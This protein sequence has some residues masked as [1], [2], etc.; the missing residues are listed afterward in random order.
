MKKNSYV[1]V[2]VDE[3]S[4]EDVEKILAN[5]GMNTSMAI[6]LFFNQIILKQGLPF[7]VKLPKRDYLKRK[8]ALASAINLT[9]GRSVPEKFNKI[10]KLYAKGDI[11]YDVALYAIK[12]EYTSHE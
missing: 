8:V 5:L 10:L 6:N 4:K 11:D 1:N 2:R 12:K 7:D 3:K 9:G